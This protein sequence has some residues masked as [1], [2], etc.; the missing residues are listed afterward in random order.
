MLPTHTEGLRG[1]RGFV[2]QVVVGLALSGVV[3]AQ[4]DLDKAVR[5][6]YDAVMAIFKSVPKDAED[7]AVRA[8]MTE[9]QT[10]NQNLIEKYQPRFGELTSGHF[11][12][13]RVYINL[14]DPESAQKHIKLF[15]EKAPQ[16]QDT[17]EA[18]LILGETHR[19]LKDW[20]S[21]IKTFESFITERPKSERLPAA[22]LALATSHLLNLDYDAA[23]KN[24]KVVLERYPEH[25]LAADAS[26]QITDALIN[27]GRIDE[28]RAHVAELL[29]KQK[30]APELL[31]REKVL[32][33]IGT[34]APDLVGIERWVGVQGANVSSV[35]GRVLVLCFFTNWSMH[36]T[37]ELQI[38]SG[39]EAEMGAEG[40]TV[41]GVTKTY[42]Q[43]K[44]ATSKGLTLDEEVQWLDRYRKNPRFV[45]QRELGIPAEKT[46]EDAENWK[47][48]EQPIT[49]SFALGATFDNHKAYDVRG[50]PYVVVIDKA[51]KIRFTREGGSTV[52]SF[53]AEALRGVVRRLLSE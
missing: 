17:E 46:N 53:P 4:N 23:I 33:R 10:A 40:L 51:G 1:G 6:D 42:K 14:A 18:L 15:L 36:C 20:G 12:V 5:T 44:D 7:E 38:L 52:A 48:F 47:E 49:V 50:V 30:D 16:H 29:K 19:A 11:D 21:A 45:L 25:Q 39:L 9:F 34:T 41:W 43:K 2:L 8:K 28:A 22:Y 26:M 3:A 31:R 24:Y 37:R 27:S 32:A 13:G 35:R